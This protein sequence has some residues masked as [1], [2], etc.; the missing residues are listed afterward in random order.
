[1]D[2]QADRFS[3]EMADALILIAQSS[4][5]GAGALVAEDRGSERPD[6]SL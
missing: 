5:A 3:G 2:I 1:M 4:A 6:E